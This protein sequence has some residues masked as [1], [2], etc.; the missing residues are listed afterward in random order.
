[1]RGFARLGDLV[2]TT[3]GIGII[4]RGSSNTFIERRPAARLVDLVLLPR[5][6]GFI[7]TGAA[8]VLINRRPAARLFDYTNPFGIIIT[9]ARKTFTR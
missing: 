1:M 3:K 2:L 8:R 7:I 5:S 6:M 4:I 9:S